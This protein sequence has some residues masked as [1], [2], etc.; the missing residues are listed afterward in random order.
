M[1]LRAVIFDFDGLLIDTESVILAGWRA[2]YGRYDLEFPTER[3]VRANVGTVKGE[4]GYFDEYS[5]LCALTGLTLDADDILRRRLALHEELLASA[6]PNPGV[7]EWIAACGRAEIALAVASSSTQAWV[8]RL[9]D[10]V[11]LFEAFSHIATR[12]D[13]GG[14]AKPDPAVYVSALRGLGVLASE[15]VAFE[16]SPPGVA[17]ARGAGIFTVAVPSEITRPLD[18][19]AADHVAESLGAFTLGDLLALPPFARS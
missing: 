9:L 10:Q 1:T 13:V 16:D 3:W 7:A 17:A 2:E 19:S 4:P 18:F 15:A 6:T 8:G 14:A 11:G 12:D 5:E